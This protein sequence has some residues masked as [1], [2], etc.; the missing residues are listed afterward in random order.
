MTAKPTSARMS[1]LCILTLA[2]FIAINEAHAG[3]SGKE[4]TKRQ[5]ESGD[6]NEGLP[7]FIELLR[8]RDGRDGRDG[9]PGPIGMKGDQGDKGDPGLQGLPG[10]ASGGAVYVRWGR[11]TC[12]NTLGTELVY[13]GRAAG[14]YFTHK[15]GTSD[16]L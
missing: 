13:S 8:G 9:E 14:T 15:G 7:P 1:S 11:T 4:V 12:P 6:S 3:P 10:P 16:Y 5:A 2:Y